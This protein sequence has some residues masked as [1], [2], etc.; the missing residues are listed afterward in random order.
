ML[1][2][3]TAAS[4]RQYSSKLCH[5]LNHGASTLRHVGSHLNQAYNVG[6]TVYQTVQPLLKELAPAIEGRATKALKGAASGYE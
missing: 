2:R 1:G 4:I 5:H 3:V 6:K